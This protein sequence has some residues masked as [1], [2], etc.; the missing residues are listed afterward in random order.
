[1]PMNIGNE[2][3][4]V[5]ID[6]PIARDL[7]AS[8][9]A[10]ARKHSTPEHHLPTG[11]EDIMSTCPWKV[12]YATYDPYKAWDESAPERMLITVKCVRAFLWDGNAS[13]ANV[14]F[15]LRDMISRPAVKVADQA[16]RFKDGSYLPIFNDIYDN[17][18]PLVDWARMSFA[19]IICRL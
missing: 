10:L 1:M 19:N 15:T 7:I 16:L 17:Q 13:F 5:M 8:Y 4:T 12:L 18:D 9:K 6:K 11:I 3:E 2:P 14:S